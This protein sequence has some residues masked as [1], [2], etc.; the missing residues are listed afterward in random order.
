[1][2]APAGCGE[3]VRAAVFLDRDGVLNAPVVRGGR[4]YPPASPDEVVLLLGVAEA[5][6][7]LKSAG[8]CLIVVSNQP[9]IARGTTTVDDVTAI[10]TTLADLLPLDEILVCPHDDAD[11]CG[12]RKP[13]PGLILAA[14]DG[15]DIDLDL[16]SLVGDRWR[17]I[18]AGRAAGVATI[19]LDRGY[20]ERRP[21]EAD[22]V[23]DELVSAVPFILH[24][25]L[26]RST[27]L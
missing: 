1:M 10:N 2:P 17:D 5:C 3:L 19:F 8:L 25:A 18:D 9:D 22:L 23:T 12:C 6:A 13:Q 24:R 16:S 21:I 27:G 11:G 14:A 7:Q 4:P 20:R 26:A 15:W